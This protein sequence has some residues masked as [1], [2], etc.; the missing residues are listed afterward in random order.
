LGIILGASL[1]SWIF[2][3]DVTFVPVIAAQS[4]ALFKQIFSGS[5]VLLGIVSVLDTREWRVVV[6]LRGGTTRAVDVA[7][8][9]GYANHSPVSKALGCIRREHVSLATRAYTHLRA[10]SR[11]AGPA[12]TGRSLSSEGNLGMGNQP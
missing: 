2:S 5:H 6:C 7:R 4:P 12:T 9:L 3:S 8:Q 11:S 1:A 10:N